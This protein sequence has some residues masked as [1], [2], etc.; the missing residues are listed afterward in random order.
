MITGRSVEVAGLSEGWLDGCR[1]LL[2]STGHETNHLFVRMTDPLPEDSRIR[3]AVDDLLAAARY[4][5]VTEVRNTIFPAALA[6]QFTDPNELIAE[7]LED[8]ETLQ[9]LGSSQGTYFGRICEYPHPDG[10]VT[11]Q[12]AN[13]I[14]KLSEARES[15]RWRAI[16]Q[17]NVYAEHKDDK[18]K[19]GFFPCMAHLSFQLARDGGVVNRLDCLA[20]YRYQD[21]M[22]KGYGNYLGLAELQRYVANA[23]GFVPGE[24]TVIAGHAQL[25]LNPAARARLEALLAAHSEAG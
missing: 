6:E 3:E 13:T 12:L 1:A 22:L 23:T 14:A 16:Y 19:R 21:M 10:T 5:S 17:L 24:L 25:T 8:Y 7:Y 20:L 15:T 2:A 18:K 11:R 9:R 4:Q